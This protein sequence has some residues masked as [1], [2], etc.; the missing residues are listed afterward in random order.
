MPMAFE[1]VAEFLKLFNLPLR[2]SLF[3][4]PTGRLAC[5]D[6]VTFFAV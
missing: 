6:F 4:V 1:Y 2:D 5:D 3:S